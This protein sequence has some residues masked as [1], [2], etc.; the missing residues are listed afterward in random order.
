M[1]PPPEESIHEL[2][3]PKSLDDLR[4]LV[5]DDELDVRELLSLVLQQYGAQV[6]T[7]SG[8]DEALRI[9]DALAPDV[10]ISDVAMPRADG[11]DLVRRYFR[12]SR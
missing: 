6:A 8:T 4:I 10:I 11:Y 7:A 1:I 9:C 5:V 2:P 3:A 12:A